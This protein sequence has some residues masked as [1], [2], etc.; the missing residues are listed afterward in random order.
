MKWKVPFPLPEYPTRWWTDLRK[1]ER[2]NYLADTL[3]FT[4]ALVAPRMMD[5]GGGDRSVLLYM[6]LVFFAGCFAYSQ[7]AAR[8]FE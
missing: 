1:A 5:L 3:L 7:I 2:F 8:H 6:A 4:F